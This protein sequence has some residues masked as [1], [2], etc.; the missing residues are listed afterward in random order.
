MNTNNDNQT[1]FVSNRSN[2][3]QKIVLKYTNFKKNA[4]SQKFYK[5]TWSLFKGKDS[6][7]FDFFLVFAAF[8]Y[9]NL[10]S[11]QFSTL[12]WGFILIFGITL[13]IELVQKLLYL[14]ILVPKFPTL[15]LTQVFSRIRKFHT[16][17]KLP[18]FVF[19]ITTIKRGFLLGFFLE[20]FKVGS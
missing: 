13:F 2:S 3:P 19:F 11:I 10:F 4:D 12:N 18:S 14:L 16:K 7:L 5:F 9:G 6:F 15:G 20:A 1:N 8:V 17:N